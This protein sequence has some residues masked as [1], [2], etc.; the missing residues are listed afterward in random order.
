MIGVVLE[1][2]IMTSIRTKL[3]ENRDKMN[4][5]IADESG[6]STSITVWG[7]EMCNS[8]QKLAKVGDV[9]AL[10]SCRINDYNGSR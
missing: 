8:I 4:L 6:Y 7:T 9:V 10:K 2:G 5:T 1:I 3:G